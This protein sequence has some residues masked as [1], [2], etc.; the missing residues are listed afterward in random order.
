LKVINF[1][2]K[3]KTHNLVE[4]IFKKIDTAALNTGVEDDSL[5]SIYLSEFD[6]DLYGALAGGKIRFLCSPYEGWI[7]S[8]VKP[9]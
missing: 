1:I 6:Q 3:R 5:H 7:S 9:E 4:V 2:S 8:M